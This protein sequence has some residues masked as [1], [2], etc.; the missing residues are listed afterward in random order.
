VDRCLARKEELN[1]E[2]SVLD[3]VMPLEDVVACCLAKSPG[4]RF[5]DFHQVREALAWHVYNRYETYLSP[6]L[7]LD[8]LGA[9]ARRL[10]ADE[11][12]NKALSF[13]ELGQ[14]QQALQAF[15]QTIERDP[16]NGKAWLGK[17]LLLMNTFHRFEEALAALEEAQRL[18]EQGAEEQ[19]LLCRKQMP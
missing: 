18:G 3:T 16:E 5:H 19:I 15:D 9:S 2:F 17:G 10:T 6:S 11:C 7:L 1:D 12:L 8:E 4:E 14:Y 13:V